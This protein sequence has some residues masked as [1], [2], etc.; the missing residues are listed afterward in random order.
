MEIRNEPYESDP[1]GAF[2][3]RASAGRNLLLLLLASL[4]LASAAL[5]GMR[6]VGR[7]SPMVILLL[8][9]PMGLAGLVVVAAFLA[10]IHSLRSS[11][12][13]SNWSVQIGSQSLVI[14]LRDY[15]N[16]I[17]GEPVPVL[18]IPLS[19]IEE[20]I[21][22]TETWTRTSS[23]KE[24]RHTPAIRRYVDL[25]VRGQDTTELSRLLRAERLR[26]ST[27][28]AENKGPA[29]FRFHGLHVLVIE[30]GVVRLVH[31]KQ[32]VDALGQL[33]K[34]SDHRQVDL[35]KLLAPD[36]SLMKARA[37]DLRGE[38]LQATALL[39]REEGLKLSEAKELLDRAFDPSQ[40]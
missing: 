20:A 11:L 12:R 28:G 4:A 38:R 7:L 9:L 36:P 37:M 1:G 5:L 19:E 35:D 40:D 8:S 14:N 13:P 22:V 24:T 3:L 15:R 18:Q 29:P 16:A 17:P 26:N 31:S 30:P 39:A 21:P 23:R 10:T 33:L 32:L 6:F 34:L 2:V 27:K 25:V